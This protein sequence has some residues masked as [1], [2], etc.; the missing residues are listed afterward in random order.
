MFFLILLTNTTLI[1]QNTQD[2]FLKIKQGYDLG[3]IQKTIKPDSTLSLSMTNSSFAAV[4]NQ[5][6][7]Y[8]FEKPFPNL[9]S[10]FLDLVYLIT[11]DETATTTDIISRNEVQYLEII[12]D[13]IQLAD[14]PMPFA[15]VPND[16][17]DALF[18]GKNTSLDLI[19][20]PLA[21]TISTGENVLVGV[22]D[23][24]VD[25]NHFDI[26][27]IQEIN[28]PITNTDKH[29]TG[30]V[31]MIAAKTNNGLGIASLAHNASIVSAPRLGDQ[32]VYALPQIPGVKIINCSWQSTC[33][34]NIALVCDGQIQDSKNLLKQ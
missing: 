30:V 13:D 9:N 28:Q 25:L 3:V 14:E 26:P 10:A 12:E 23:T 27:V 8:K 6:P 4:M 19:K 7:I 33:T 20:A 21:W 29:G 17:T 34:Y 31:G 16:Y 15:I 5:K 2:Y 1:G 32:A 11:L 22:A 24:K 18:G